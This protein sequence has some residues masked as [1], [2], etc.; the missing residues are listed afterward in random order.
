M[1]RSTS[2]SAPVIIDEERG[3]SQERLSSMQTL[4]TNEADLSP[5]GFANA[6]APYPP[7][8][9]TLPTSGHRTVSTLS[10]PSSMAVTEISPTVGSNPVLL[11]SD[12]TTSEDWFDARTLER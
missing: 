4:I 11:R 7:A 2:P 5:D 9:S 10:D 1:T 12:T 3:N 8:Y 6:T